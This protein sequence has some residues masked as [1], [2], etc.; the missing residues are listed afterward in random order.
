MNNHHTD[1]PSKDFT[2][3]EEAVNNHQCHQAALYDKIMDVFSTLP[4]IMPQILAQARRKSDFFRK[5][6]RTP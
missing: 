3:K 6:P 5:I 4:N 2:W 1:V